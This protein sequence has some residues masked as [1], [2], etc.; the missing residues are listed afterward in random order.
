MERT[1]NRKRRTGRYGKIC[2]ACTR[3]SFY[4][5]YCYS[6]LHSWLC[7]CKPLLWLVAERNTCS[8]PQQKG[9]FRAS[10]SGNSPLYVWANSVGFIKVTLDYCKVWFSEFIWFGVTEKST[11]H[12]DYIHLDK[13]HLRCLA[14]TTVI[15]VFIINMLLVILIAHIWIQTFFLKLKHDNVIWMIFKFCYL[16]TQWLL[17]QKGWWVNTKYL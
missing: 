2:A 8:H 16:N 4:S 3:E 10:W 7:H 12:S 17:H 14:R 15:M 5:K 6:W 11:K 1:S 9:E 13:Y